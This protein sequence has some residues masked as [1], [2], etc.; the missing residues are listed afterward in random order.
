[1]FLGASAAEPDEAE[2]LSMEVWTPRMRGIDEAHV[3]T[4]QP[5][6]QAN[7]RVSGSHGDPGRTKGSEAPKGEGPQAARRRDSGETA[8]LRGAVAAPS[9]HFP[10]R[11]RLRKR[12]EFLALQREGRRRT[13]PNFIVITRTKSNEPSRLGV[14]TSRK[15]GGAPARNRVRRM[16]REFFRQQRPFLD[17]PRDVLVIARRGASALRYWDVERELSRALETR[18]R[19]D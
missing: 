13:A 19:V 8:R 4:K 6:T 11:Y 17:P 9:Q 15:V 1:M 10:P 5:E 3:P 12:P 16:V 14:T 18:K 7:T 2:N